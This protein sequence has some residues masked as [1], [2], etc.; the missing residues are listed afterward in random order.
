M[1]AFIQ[2]SRYPF[3]VS[4]G[5]S[6]ISVLILP[7]SARGELIASDSNAMPGWHSTL[8]TSGSTQ[9]SPYKYLYVDIDYAVYDKGQFN[10]SFPGKDPS[11]GTQYVYAYQLFNKPNPPSTDLGINIFTVGLDGNE[12]PANIMEIDNPNPP[13]GKTSSPAFVGT[14]PTSAKWSYSPANK[15]SPSARSKIL[16]FTSKFGPEWDFANLTGWSGSTTPLNTYYL[17]SPVPEPGTLLGLTIA[18]LFFF[19]RMLRGIVFK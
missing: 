7:A 2:R 4:F 12:S 16:L 17:P 19:V 9:V 6:L 1:I 10:L 8:Q 18:G 11:G 13:T 15:V 14:P 5:I 3:W